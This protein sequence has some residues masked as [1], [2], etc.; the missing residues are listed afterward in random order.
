MTTK[1]IRGD[2]AKF[3]K[4]IQGKLN[5]RL[6]KFIETGHIFKMRPDGKG[7]MSVPLPHIDQPQFRFGKANKGVGRGDGNPDDVVDRDWEPGHGPGAGDKGHGGIMVDV[8]VEDVIQA[9]EEQLHLP[10]M[11]PKN[12]NTFD[13]VETRYNNISRNGPRSLI[14][15]RRTIK[16]AMKRSIAQGVWGQKVLLPGYSVPMPV[17]NLDNN[18]FLY[19]QWNQVRIPRANCLL[20]FGRDG[21][22]SMDDI[23]CNIVSDLAYWIELWISREYEKSESVY[24]WHDTEAKEVSQHD[25]YHERHGGG[26]TCSSV[27][28]LVQKLIKLK[29]SPEKW[30]IYFIYFGDGDNF[31]KDNAQFLK[32]LLELEDDLNM[33]AIVQILASDWEGSLRQYIDDNIEEF[34]DASFIRTTS[35]GGDKGMDA[36]DAEDSPH[37]VNEDE[38]L[39]EEMRKAI[40]DI[41]GVNEDDDEMGVA[42]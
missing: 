39:D 14:H 1:K 12:A 41:L 7:K 23:K 24:L 35:V 18:D 22:G 38:R 17:I 25:F 31:S 13:S 27:L 37:M 30:N 16:Q 29:Y 40:V 26:T 34:K 19:R 5:E 3:R 8:D 4:M 36:D 32:L 20:I 15:K 2:H 33:A 6:K 9:I 28:Q 11:K 10:R 21:S 42:I